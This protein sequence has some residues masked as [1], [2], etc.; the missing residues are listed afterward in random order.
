MKYVTFSDFIFDFM[1]DKN[2]KIWTIYDSNN[3]PLFQGTPYRMYI[4]SLIGLLE[5]RI[6]EI[7]FVK[8]N[9]ILD[10]KVKKEED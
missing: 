10:C 3:T 7:D 8:E 5:I 1:Y 2:Q 4:M 6:K 9:I